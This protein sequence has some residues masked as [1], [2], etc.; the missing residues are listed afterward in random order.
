MQVVGFAPIHWGVWSPP[1]RAGTGKS[2][3]PDGNPDGN[4]GLEEKAML[5]I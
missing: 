1:E 5:L 2:V 3:P 4:L